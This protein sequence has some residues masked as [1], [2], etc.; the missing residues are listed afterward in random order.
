MGRLNLVGEK[1]ANQFLDIGLE[2]LGGAK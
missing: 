1:F 2:K